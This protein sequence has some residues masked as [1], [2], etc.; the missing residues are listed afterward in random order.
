[1]EP[2][3]ERTMKRV[4]MWLLVAG[5][6]LA[7][8]YANFFYQTIVAHFSRSVAGRIPLVLMAIIG[9]GFAV[10][11][12]YRKRL[13]Q[14]LP[15]LAV[16]ALIVA[17]MLIG[18]PN[19]NKHIHIPEYI[20]MAWLV[21]HALSVDC[22]NRWVYL[23]TFVCSALLGAVDEI[24]QG[25]HPQRFFSGTDMAVNAVSALVGV[26]MLAALGQRMAPVP[27]PAAVGWKT[28]T[29]AA[30]VGLGLLGAGIS[31][32]FLFGFKGPGPLSGVYPLWLAYC[33]GLFAF[34]A[35][36]VAIANGLPY[37]EKRSIGATAPDGIRVGMTAALCILTVI[38]LLVL[39]AVLAERCFQ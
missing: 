36:L 18:I 37:G 15:T 17:F 16:G 22:Q 3:T 24:A 33:N 6:S 2:V 31:C 39:Y 32:G 1:M 7:L 4:G 9:M 29:A 13:R 27:R 10:M 25:I 11:G 5:Y 26:M 20:L 14:W 12:V 8:P 21:Y 35:L 23:W 19:P 34:V 28:S 38:H 30:A